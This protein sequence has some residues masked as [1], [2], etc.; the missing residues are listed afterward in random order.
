M[1]F[2]FLGSVFVKSIWGGSEISISY[3]EIPKGSPTAILEGLIFTV[4]LSFLC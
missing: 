3:L 4:G 2:T 1:K